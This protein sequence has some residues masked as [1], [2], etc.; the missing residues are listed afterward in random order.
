MKSSVLTIALLAFLGVAVLALVDSS[1]V[2]QAQDSKSALKIAVVNM[3]GT[4]EDSVIYDELKRNFKKWMEV[5]MGE[6]FKEEK[7]KYDAKLEE[8]AQ[9]R[10]GADADPSEL[11]AIQREIAVMK[12]KLEARL[13]VQEAYAKEM[14]RK[15]MTQLRAAVHIVI[16]EVAKKRGFDIV[17]KRV[18]LKESKDMGSGAEADAFRAEMFAALSSQ[19]TVLYYDEENITDITND[20]E[21]AL[22]PQKLKAMLPKIEKRIRGG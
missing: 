5:D 9:V 3:A 15:M 11:E 7:K 22:K 2:S 14:Q 6:K 20:V 19:A 10:V 8:E 13:K 12:E 4:Y 18:E 17:L 16:D 1:D 21:S